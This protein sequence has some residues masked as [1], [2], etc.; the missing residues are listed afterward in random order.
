MA[1]L[2]NHSL[3]AGVPLLAFLTLFGILYFASN[4]KAANSNIHLQTDA[5]GWH[6]GR[7]TYFGASPE[8]VETFERVRGAGSYGDLHYGSCG[9]YRKPQVRRFLCDWRE[10]R[11]S[12]KRETS[13]KT[14]ISPPAKTSKNLIKI[15]IK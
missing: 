8:L 5:D 6:R 3:L 11:E 15:K 13:K 12:K 10:K 9:M 2:L 4:A 1:R 14:K 7:A